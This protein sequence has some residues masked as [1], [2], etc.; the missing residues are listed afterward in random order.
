MI[1]KAKVRVNQADPP[2]YQEVSVRPV[3][4]PGSDY[5]YFVVH[6]LIRRNGLCQFAWVVSD[7][8]TGLRVTLP[9]HGYSERKAI[10]LTAQ[11]IAEFFPSPSMFEDIIK[12]HIAKWGIANKVIEA[13]WPIRTGA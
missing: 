12:Q 4:V 2:E 6:H 13:D 10:E 3:A 7:Y 8:Q 9:R 1:T 11:L 5:R